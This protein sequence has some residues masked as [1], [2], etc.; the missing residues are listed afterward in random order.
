[1]ERQTI[2]E[3]LGWTFIRIRGSEYFKSPD[4]TIAKIIVTLQNYG[5][6]PEEN[7]PLTPDDNYYPLRSAIC[8]RA[9]ELLEEWHSQNSQT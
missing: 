5:L 3:R 6:Y 2:L 9:H 8:Q 1:M 4:S 7:T